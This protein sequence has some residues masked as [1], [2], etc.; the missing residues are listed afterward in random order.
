LLTPLSYKHKEGKYELIEEVEDYPEEK[1]KYDE[2]KYGK[3]EKKYNDYEEGE[4]EK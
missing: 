3:E 1:K 4:K 2:Y